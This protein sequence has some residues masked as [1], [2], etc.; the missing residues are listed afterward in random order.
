MKEQANMKKIMDSHINDIAAGA[1][2]SEK[3]IEYKTEIDELK[4]DVKRLRQD[5]NHY[6]NQCMALENQLNNVKA[7]VQDQKRLA[8]QAPELKKK[9]ADLL[10]EL[11]AYKRGSP[12]V[13]SADPL[14]PLSKH[15]KPDS[16]SSVSRILFNKTDDQGSDEQENLVSNLLGE[17]NRLKAELGLKKDSLASR[18]Q[19]NE[20]RERGNIN[21]KRLNSPR[22]K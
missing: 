22:L 9:I 7:E 5:R 17:I 1:S 16:S 2:T 11:D 18:D 13:F 21:E 10:T 6:K 8:A 15:S 12:S 4:S 20:V 19:I 3:I 14:S